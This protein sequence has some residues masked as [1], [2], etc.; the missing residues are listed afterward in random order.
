[1]SLLLRYM[2]LA[3]VPQVAQIDRMAFD[4]PW[5]ERSYAYEVTEASYSYMVVLEDQTET[6]PRGWRRWLSAWNGHHRSAQ[7]TIIGYGGLWKIADEAHI[8]T[9]AVHPDHRGRGWGEVL[10]AAMIRRAIALDA[11][12]VVLEVRVSNT[13]AQNLYHKYHFETAGVKPGYYRNNDEDAYEM[14]LILTAEQ[15]QRL[16]ASFVELQARHGFSDSYTP[17]EPPNRTAPAQRDTR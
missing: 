14:R 5:S 9:I 16:A 2:V 17:N 1:M 6:P 3:D 7:R 11:A 8:S 13:R 15:R 4:L 10:L 12:Y